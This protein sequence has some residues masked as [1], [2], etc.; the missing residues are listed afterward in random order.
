MIE[1]KYPFTFTHPIVRYLKEIINGF[2][3]R[4]QKNVKIILPFSICFE[5]YEKHELFHHD[6][7]RIRMSFIKYLEQE[8]AVKFELIKITDT[9]AFDD[10]YTGKNKDGDFNTNFVLHIL[11]MNTI[12]EI[13]NNYMKAKTED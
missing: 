5:S 7:E 11:N 10:I 3:N 9:R 13:W 8:K 1:E 2:E 4:K 6:S 12:Y